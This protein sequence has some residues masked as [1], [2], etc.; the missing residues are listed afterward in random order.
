VNHQSL[1]T[2]NQTSEEPKSR[3]LLDAQIKAEQQDLRQQILQSSS[4]QDFSQVYSTVAFRRPW[5]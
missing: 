1:S 3:F 2:G 4:C 5:L